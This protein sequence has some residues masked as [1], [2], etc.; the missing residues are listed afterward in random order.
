MFNGLLR[1]R[2]GVSFSDAMCGFKFIN[3]SLYRRLTE[4]FEFTDDWFFAT[5]VAVRAEW[6]GAKVLDMPVQWTD[7]PD[8][9]K[10]GARL[11]NLAR[12]Y[13]AG[14]SELQQEMRQLQRAKPPGTR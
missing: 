13:L 7:D 4:Q 2:L 3:R 1:L 6:L 5:Q 8:N 10:S 14:I 12:L 11:V 9:S